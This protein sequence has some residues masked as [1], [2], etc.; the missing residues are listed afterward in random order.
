MKKHLLL[1]LLAALLL[2]TTFGSDPA[3]A[4]G[5]PPIVPAPTVIGTLGNNDWYTSDVTVYWDTSVFDP[6]WT[7]VEGCA[8][9]SAPVVINSD[10][11]AAGINVLCIVENI[12]GQG[13]NGVNIKR[14]ATPPVLELVSPAQNP[15]S[16]N[17]GS[18]LTL[19]A[20]AQD[21]NP[22]T[23]GWDLDEDGA[24]DA[25]NPTSVTIPGLKG[26]VTPCFIVIATDEA[27][28]T[29][30]IEVE[31]SIVNLP[32]NIDG[33]VV[34][35]MIHFGGAVQVSATT[36][37]P[38]DDP[39]TARVDW[40]DNQ[41]EEAVVKSDGSIQAEH[42]YAGAGTFPV[43]LILSDDEGL[44]VSDTRNVWI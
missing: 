14:D 34:P 35:T 6:S 1:T 42:T 19:Q 39:L 32:P 16:A 18:T 23:V 43:T 15:T 21:A 29:S 40:G 4:Q 10:T 44:T 8:D 31:V 12:G 25:P 24:L 38:G 22:F 28:N 27:G 2:A 17:E 13:G 41:L 37:D 11:T 30:Q 3:Q 33:W 20:L 26:S 7:I 5:F 36:S 9:V